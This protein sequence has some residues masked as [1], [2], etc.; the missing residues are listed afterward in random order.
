M[1][2]RLLLLLLHAAAALLLSCCCCYCAVS[3]LREWHGPH[4]AHHRG[5]VRREGGLA[6]IG[7]SWTDAGGA[8]HPGLGLVGIDTRSARAAA[9]TVVTRPVS[10]L[11][12]NGMVGWASG[13]ATLTRKPGVA[14]LAELEDDVGGSD[15]VIGD[16][17]IGTQLH[18]PVLALN[19]ELAD[20][21]LARALG[22]P[23]WDPLPIPSVEV[24][25][26]RRIAEATG[27]ARPPRRRWRMRG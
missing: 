7:R 20:L 1:I 17:V 5:G 21:V 3:S 9:A 24:A 26:S 11:G 27:S 18:G 14:P 25:R 22:G 10:A 23:R 8:T 2:S 12:L 15:G 19:P 6:A 13:A 16:G 4:Q